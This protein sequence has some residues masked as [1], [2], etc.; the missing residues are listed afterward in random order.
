MMNT[1][2]PRPVESSSWQRWLK[3]ALHLSGKHLALN[4][5]LVLLTVGL[6]APFSPMLLLI[7]S[8]A[9]VGVFILVAH[10]AASSEPVT[11]TLKTAPAGILRVLFCSTA[12]VSIMAV[13]FFLILMIVKGTA[14]G[15][16]GA[17]STYVPPDYQLSDFLVGSKALFAI[18][19]WLLVILP[20][21]AIPL[22]VCTNLPMLLCLDH[23]FKGLNQNKFIVFV[24]FFTALAMMGGALF[25]GLTVVPL[26]PILGSLMYA[27]Y[28]HIFMGASPLETSDVK[29][30]SSVVDRFLQPK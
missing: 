18:G 5:C 21:F 17:T 14:I 15:G 30:K 23:T 6:L 28:R 11:Q 10:S 4:V 24:V 12:A 25:H 1:F 27:A 29:V 2:G 3:E 22:M 26:F 7:V 19:L 9:L 16:A 8:P 20:W 13:A